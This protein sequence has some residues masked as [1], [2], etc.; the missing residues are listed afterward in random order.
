M[1]L[2]V[3][4]GNPGA[5]YQDTRHNAGFLVVDEVARRWRCGLGKTR[6]GA[7]TGR[8]RVAGEDVLLAQPQR[9]M[10]R[11]GGP[12]SALQCFH[13]LPLDRVVVIHDDL[14]LPLGAV[15]IKRGGGH[16]GHNGLRDLHEQIG[17]D[18]VRVRLGISRP[19]PEQDTVDWVLGRW[20]EDERE[21]LPSVVERAADAVEAIV[22]DGAL[23]AMNSF[24][25]RSRSRTPARDES[26]PDDASIVDPPDE[27]RG[28]SSGT[29]P[30]APRGQ[31]AE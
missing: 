10:N 19:A 5:E 13:Q 4:L 15:R 16:G 26:M 31:G 27:P 25:V 9:Y 7:V 1:W 11:S 6:L 14:D 28:A 17:A 8:A 23:L 29:P 22:T 30:H 12:T 18:F 20:T 21:Q 24:N 2:V 3:G